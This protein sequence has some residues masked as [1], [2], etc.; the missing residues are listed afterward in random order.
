MVEQA[1]AERG[2]AGASGGMGSSRVR[3]HGGRWWCKREQGAVTGGGATMSRVRLHDHEQGELRLRGAAPVSAS[4]A[5]GH[6][7]GMDDVAMK[8]PC[9]VLIIE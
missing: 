2:H 3:P 7:S 6:Q 9:L 1:R 4:G 8:G 5:G